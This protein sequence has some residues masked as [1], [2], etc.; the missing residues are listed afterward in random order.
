MITLGLTGSIAMGKSTVA[1]LF[2][3]EGIAV[4]DADAAVYRLMQPDGRAFAEIAAAFPDVIIDGAIDRK[5]LGRDVFKRPEKRTLLEGILHPM[6][7]EARQDWVRHHEAEG[8][9][10]VVLDVPLLYETG[11]E[12]SCDA[13]VVVSASPWQQRRRAMARPGMTEQKLDAILD[14]Q[15]DDAEKRRRADFVIPA[16]Y[17]ISTSRWYVRRIIAALTERA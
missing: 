10:L 6:V 9:A 2:R 8:A 4:H 1:G 13:V 3:D 15:M 5:S 16:N 12:K 14:A 17:G 11:T 7:R